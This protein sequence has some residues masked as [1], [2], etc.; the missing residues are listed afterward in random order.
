MP[1]LHL[2]KFGLEQV[3]PSSMMSQ[4]NLDELASE[5]ASEAYER[6]FQ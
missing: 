3:R 4:K 6:E 5:Q 1:L 2:E